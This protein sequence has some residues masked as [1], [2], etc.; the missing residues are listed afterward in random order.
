MSDGKILRQTHLFQ[1]LEQEHAIQY[2]RCGGCCIQC[3]FFEP[4][5]QMELISEPV[6][7][8]QLDGVCRRYPP[9]FTPIAEG[10][11]SFETRA[12]HSF[13]QPAV[14]FRDTCGEFK[15]DAEWERRLFYGL[16]DADDDICLTDV[17]WEAFFKSGR[18]HRRQLRDLYC[19]PS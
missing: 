16:E 11:H 7:R 19:G 9:V 5:E 13:S 8:V 3:A 4:E 2:A 6:K 17:E 12:V 1:W 15:Y 10:S 14:G 18:L